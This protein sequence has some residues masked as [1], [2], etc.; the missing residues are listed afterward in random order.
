LLLFYFVYLNK[1]LSKEKFH[2]LVLFISLLLCVFIY[3]DCTFIP[4]KG[5]DEIV[6]NKNKYNIPNKRGGSGRYNYEI[7]TNKSTHDVTAFVYNSVSENDTI[8]LY[9]SA[10]TH[11]IQKVEIKQ[12]VGKLIIQNN[13]LNVSTGYIFLWVIGIGSIIA[14]LVYSYLPYEV[15]KRNLSYLV[16]IT[17]LVAFLFHIR[18]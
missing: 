18:L 8:K 16:L 6:Q 9:Y 15:S 5:R 14:Q 7:K 3:A 1:K 13:Y 11:S 10:V 17:T 4:Q 12:D 2:R